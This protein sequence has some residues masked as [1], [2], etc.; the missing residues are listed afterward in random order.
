MNSKH[1]ARLRV[2]LIF[3]FL[4]AG[5]LGVALYW[6]QIVKGK[7]YAYR[8]DKQYVKPAVTF[9]DRGSIFFSSKDGT[10]VAAATVAAG[11]LVYMNPS[12]IVN[13]EQTFDILSNYI[14]LDKNDFLVRSR[15]PGDHY[16]E[17]AHRINED[18]ARTIQGLG[19]V[20][21]SVA[22]ETWRLY[23]GNIL[24]AQVLGI[25]GQNTSSGVEGRY[26]LERSYESTLNRPEVGSAVSSFAKL[27]SNDA[28]NSSSTNNGL[29]T[30]TL[31]KKPGDIIT[32]LE[33]TVTTYVEKILE[34]TQEQWHPD[35]IGAIIM[36]PKTG[37]IVTAISS[38]TFNPNNISGIKDVHIFSNP[39]VEH[40]YEMGSIMKPLTVAIGIDSGSI[41][42][43]STYN[44]TGTMTLNGK[45]ISNY[46]GKARG[47]TTIQELLNKSLNIGAATVALKTGAKAMSSYFSS[48]GLGE[49]T[50][51]DLPN[52]ATG[53]IGNLKSGK[54]IDVATASYGQGIAVSPME[55]IRSLAILANGGYLVKP[56]IV[57]SIEYTDGTTKNIDIVKTGPV[58]K[59][60]TTDEVTNMLV[61][62]VDTSLRN[63]TK[64]RDHYSVAAKTGT[65]QIPDHTK[66]GYY[67]DRYLHSFFGFF[68]AYNPRFIVFLYQVYPRGAQYASETLTDPFD[69]ITTF[70]LDYYNIPPDR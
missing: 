45:K 32:S 1:R 56:H 58:L 39:L 61:T 17:L 43:S 11:Y 44:D 3:I 57:K 42:A 66:G 4:A 50:G 29:S 49:K 30:T 7:S 10:K 8:A 18:V 38:P 34:K 23:P 46:D 27:F 22:R 28:D 63:G 12:L 21:V 20:G 13:P 48:F 24:E 16:E 54:D 40:V 6:T 33:P 25:I 67:S 47:I 37:E 5:V 52:E 15:K 59:K 55:M 62:V 35:E 51:I 31:V 41:T 60:E 19:L 36:D 9:F 69:E 53:L 68:P 64:K 2:V 26:G 70:L 65:A 14:D